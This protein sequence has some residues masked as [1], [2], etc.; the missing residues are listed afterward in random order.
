MEFKTGSGWRCCY[1][2]ETGLYTAEIGGG[3][4]HDLYEINKEI[5]DRV[6]APDMETPIGLIHQGGRH[7]YMAVDDRCGPP[8]TVIL[9]TDY[10]KLCPWAKTVTSGEVW[11]EDMTDAAVEVFACEANNREQRRAKKAEREK[12]KNQ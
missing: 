11:D 2:P 10:K 6:D 3:V 7:L 9:D 8:Y 4:N 5:Y 12:K 1:D